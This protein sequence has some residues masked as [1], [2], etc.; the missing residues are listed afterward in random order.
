MMFE[1]VD[2][3]PVLELDD[4]QSWRLLEGTKH[5][6]LVVSVAGEPDIFPVNYVT[7][8]RKIYLRTAPGNKL[9]QLTINSTVLFE[10]DGILSEEAWSVVLRGKARVLSN[11][12][13]L[14]AVEE[15]GLKTWVPTLKDFYVEIEPTSV[16]GRHFEFGEQPEREI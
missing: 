14:A 2:G 5:G 6:R 10:T 1:H 3:Q 12:A 11:S 7:A 16:S 4:E 9:A 8:N 13:E 15:L